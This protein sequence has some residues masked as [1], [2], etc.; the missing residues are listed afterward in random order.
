MWRWQRLLGAWALPPELLAAAPEDPYRLPAGLLAHQPR[1]L[2]DPTGRPVEAHLPDGGTLLDVGCGPGTRAA[3]HAGRARVVGVEPRGELA[4][5][6]RRAGLEVIEEGWPEAGARAPVADVVL[7]T[8]VLYDVA[9]IVA[10]VAALTTHARA[11][12]VIEL[13]AVHP[14][15]RLAPLFARFHGLALPDGPTADDAVEAIADGLGVAVARERWHHP[16]NRYPDL[17]AL[18]AQRRRQLC[19]PASRDDEVAEALAGTY[20]V[21]DDGTVTLEPRE[22]V[23]LRWPG[24]A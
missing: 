3:L 4:A 9:D 24:A 12:V 13:G 2:D 20:E 16:G 1:S 14:W 8:H 21:A 5:A 19:L 17:A 6:A 15:A 23:T 7:C 18:V 11:A 22:V 10:F